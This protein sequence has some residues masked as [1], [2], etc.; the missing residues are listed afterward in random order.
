[1]SDSTLYKR[2]MAGKDNWIIFFSCLLLLGWC[3]MRLWVPR[4][5]FSKPYSTLLY[6]SN[7]KVDILMGARIAPDGQWRFPT[8]EKIPEKFTICL[9]HYEDKRF[10]YHF[11]IDPLAVVRAFHTKI[12]GKKILSGGST[13]TMQLARIARGNQNRTIGQKLIEMLWAVYFETI[14]SK[15][16]IL[17]LY[18]SHA[19]FGGNVVGIEAAAWRYFGRSVGELSWAEYATLAVL[20]NSPALIHPGR[21]RSDLKQKRDRLLKKLYDEQ[22]LDRT[23]YE[24]ACLEQLPDKPIPLPNEAPHLLDRLSAEN[25]NQKRLFTT[26]D[27]NL[28]HQV[29]NLVNR[30][31]AEYRSN[32][33][34]NAAVLVADV[35]TGETL[36]YVGN[37]TDQQSDKN[38]GYQVDLI[39]SPRSTGSILKPFLYAAMLNDGLI[40]PSTLISDVPLNINGFSPQNYNKTFY[41]AVPAHVAIERS[42]NVP[43]VRMLSE[44]NTGRFMT[45]LKK[46]GMSTLR[47]SEDHYGASL[48]LGGAEGTLWDLSGM[49]AS[50]ARMLNHYHDYNGRYDSDDLHPLHIIPVENKKEI[51]SITDDR[52]H[53]ESFLSY[54]SIW[55]MFDAMSGLNRPEEEADWQQFSSMKQ[56]AWK[57]GTSY[58][59]RDA[60]AI[61]I[62]PRYVVGVWVGNATGEGR[63]GLTG[64][65]YAAP[66]LFDTFSLLQETPWFDMPYDELELVP[67]CR[68][69]GHKASPLCDQIDSVYI[70]QKGL[71]TSICPYHKLI[72]LSSDG[73][74]RVNSSCES[75]S[76]MKSRSWFVLPPAQAYYYK[77]YHVDYESLPPLKP[78]CE[79]DQSRQMAIL[80]PEHG[81]VLYQPKGF[82]GKKEKVVL[83]A[84]HTRADATIY[85]HLDDV[86]LG[87]TRHI[88]QRAELLEPGNHILSLI[89]EE[90]NRRSILFEVRE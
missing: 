51:N 74:Y 17:N 42:L 34:F 50:L 25:I 76:Q 44:Y 38:H 37:V 86:F 12:L 70:P 69:S 89:D 84:T 62:T 60:W 47:F 41:G 8:S 28:Q 73:L 82:S 67:I 45:L 33:I 32:Y 87:E 53:D 81:A 75:V 4:P 52:L 29:Q 46:L 31:S 36:A 35:E 22:V 13:L 77:N 9:T 16:D 56:V 18:A 3:I 80:Y 10:Y 71:A 1:M 40:L 26:L 15:E 30:Y 57:T 61:G 72:H 88:H 6:T 49:Y 83:R 20:P 14:Y 78:G 54:A 7:Q 11:G 39:T 55:F 58:G 68:K 21:N 5:L 85:W 66:I 27:P 24:L 59:G 19:P 63:S 48:I 65:G 90:G 23:E 64:V 43:L 2:Y 79:E